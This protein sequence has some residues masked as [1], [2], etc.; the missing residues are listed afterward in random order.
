MSFR[1]SNGGEN[2]QTLKVHVLGQING[3]RTPIEIR[4]VRIGSAPFWILGHVPYRL[5]E[6]RLGLAC[7]A[8]ESPRIIY[9][10]SRAR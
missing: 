5:A 6:L 4:R 10:G 3:R 7:A 8:P 1:E 2:V 9:C